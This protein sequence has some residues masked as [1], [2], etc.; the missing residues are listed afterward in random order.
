MVIVKGVQGTEERSNH[1]FFSLHQ[2][3]TSYMIVCHPYLSR[4]V[5]WGEVLLL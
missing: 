4:A 2:G 1:L 3:A 5:R